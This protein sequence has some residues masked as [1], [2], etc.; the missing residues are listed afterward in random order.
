MHWIIGLTSW[1][2]KSREK[3][4]LGKPYVFMNNFS[5]LKRFIVCLRVLLNDLLFFLSCI[6]LNANDIFLFYIYI[7][8][9]HN[10]RSQHVFLNIVSKVITFFSN[11]SLSFC[12]VKHFAIWYMHKVE[13]IY[14]PSTY[15]YL[16]LCFPPSP[17]THI[18]SIDCSFPISTNKRI[19]SMQ[20]WVKL[21]A[22][23]WSIG[24]NEMFLFLL[25][26]AENW[27]FPSFKYMNPNR[28]RVKQSKQQYQSDFVVDLVDFDPR[29]Y[30]RQR[31]KWCVQTKKKTK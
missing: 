22:L 2:R 3:N 4:E 13:Y 8:Y 10:V 17:N 31:G 26:F 12:F 20:M 15:I 6:Y 18:F 29:T 24:T 11:Y 14:K 7:Y 19:N 5:S 27:D 28:W 16:R 23:N 25:S 21:L 9:D 30:T 1:F